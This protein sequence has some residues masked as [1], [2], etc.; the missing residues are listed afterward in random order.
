MC[1][2]LLSQQSKNSPIYATFKS[3]YKNKTLTP[4]KVHPSKKFNKHLLQASQ[5]YGRRRQ[6]TDCCTTNTKTAFPL[7]SNASAIRCPGWR[8]KDRHI[9]SP[10]WHLWY[11]SAMVDL[12]ITP[13]LRK[14]LLLTGIYFDCQTN[15]VFRRLHQLAAFLIIAV[16]KFLEIKFDDW[17]W[18]GI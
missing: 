14:L 17:N 5:D 15:P 12:T 18:Q 3:I 1:L 8:P 10:F 7:N 6:N 11:K 16:C 2:K 13:R 9:K 4:T